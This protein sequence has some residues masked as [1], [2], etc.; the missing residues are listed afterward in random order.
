MG[1]PQQQLSL[2]R[3]SLIDIAGFTTVSWKI[4]EGP[5]DLA[6][7][8]AIQPVQFPDLASSLRTLSATTGRPSIADLKRAGKVSAV[9]KMMLQFDGDTL[10]D[11]EVAALI[12][13]AQQ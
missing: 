7:D 5:S 12:I 10:T 2:V 6:N 3:N 1:P 13:M 4:L 9:C 11:E 8:L